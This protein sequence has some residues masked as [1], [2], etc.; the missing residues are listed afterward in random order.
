MT[1]VVVVVLALN[2]DD[3]EPASGPAPAEP[4]EQAAPAGGGALRAVTGSRARANV[5]VEDGRL[6]MDVR[7]LPNPPTGG[8]VVWLYDSVTEARS[9]VGFRKGR[10]KVSARLP[11]NF[12]RY[13]FIDVSCELADG[14]RNHSGQS[15]LRVPVGGLGG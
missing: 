10:A 5:R 2:G 7:G 8:Y 13:R 15:L 1:L 4:A 14:N 12:R 11:A 6:V 9:L 3:D